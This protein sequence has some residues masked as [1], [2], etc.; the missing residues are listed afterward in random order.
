[1]T[2]ENPGT[3]AEVAVVS[4]HMDDTIIL[5]RRFAADMGAPND[6]ANELTYADLVGSRQRVFPGDVV[7]LPEAEV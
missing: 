3:E 4:S 6:P 1:M 2:G 7:T 5:T